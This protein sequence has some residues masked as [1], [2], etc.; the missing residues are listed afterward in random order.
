MVTGSDAFVPDIFGNDTRPRFTR[1]YVSQ[2]STQLQLLEFTVTP[3]SKLLPRTSYLP[4]ALQDCSHVWLRVDRTKLPLE[5]LHKGP[6]P[7]L[8]RDSKTMLV[9][10]ANISA[11]VSLDRVKPCYLRP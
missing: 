11:I 8:E 1:D 2:L 10:Q 6:F 3:S 9:Q 4:K 5:A 7:V